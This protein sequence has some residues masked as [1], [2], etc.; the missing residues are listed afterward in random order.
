MAG[1]PSGGGPPE[2]SSWSGTRAFEVSVRSSTASLPMAT[3]SN[4]PRMSEP[5]R[6]G[7]IELQPSLVRSRIAQEL[8]AFEEAP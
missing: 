1:I 3:A 5:I 4:P 7:V 2:T 6:P 8:R